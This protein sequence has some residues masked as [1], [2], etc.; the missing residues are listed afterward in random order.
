MIGSCVEGL[1]VN[2]V[3]KFVETTGD[4][5]DIDAIGIVV[6]CKTVE[7]SDTP[8]EICNVSKEV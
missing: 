4:P 1:E 8:V 7:D 3:G 2:V 6:C 5:V